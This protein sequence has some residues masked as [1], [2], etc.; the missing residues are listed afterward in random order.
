MYVGV[1]Y[2]GVVP[3]AIQLY[4]V[5]CRVKFTSCVCLPLPKRQHPEDEVDAARERRSGANPEA[6]DGEES[7]VMHRAC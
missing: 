4:I 6:D 3:F 7:C 5:A 1:I 2:G